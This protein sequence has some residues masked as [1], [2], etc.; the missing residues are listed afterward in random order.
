MRELKMLGGGHDF[1][2]RMK[3]AESTGDFVEERSWQY[4]ERR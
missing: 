3:R 1:A 4:G 2:K